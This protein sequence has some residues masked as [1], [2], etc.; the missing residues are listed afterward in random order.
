M[1]QLFPEV[2]LLESPERTCPTMP[3]TNAEAT[4]RFS[5]LFPLLPALIVFFFFFNMHLTLDK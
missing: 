5:Q 3:V 1:R 4:E 2:W